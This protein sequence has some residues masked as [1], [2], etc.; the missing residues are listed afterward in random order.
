MK[1]KRFYPLAAAVLAIQTAALLPSCKSDAP[2]NPMEFVEVT[3]HTSITVPASGASYDLE[4][5]SNTNW[6]V[7]FGEAGEW[8]TAEPVKGTG[9]SSVK[10]TVAPYTDGS[11]AR[12][13]TIR[14]SS[15]R[16]SSTGVD[17]PLTQNPPAQ[18]G[19]A[20]TVGEIRAL[21]SSI[22]VSEPTYT[23]TQNVKL[24]VNVYSDPSQ[25]NFRENALAIQDGT[26]AN[27]GIVLQ[28]AAALQYPAG[29][30]LEIDVRNA[31]LT[32]DAD[33]ILVLQAES[34]SKITSTESTA[35]NLTPVTTDLAG[36][37]SG[38]YESMYVEIQ[39][40]E[41]IL[42]ETEDAMA[43][44]VTMENFARD[45]FFMFTYDYALFASEKVPAGSGNLRGIVS[46]SGG[47]PA[48]IPQSAADFSL[49]G[50]RFGKK[51]ITLPHILSL[52][53]AGTSNTAG[54]KYSTRSTLD[55]EPLLSDNSNDALNRDTD[56]MYVYP[57]DN[58]GV[59]LRF[60]DLTYGDMLT[61][62]AKAGD[63]RIVFWHENSGHHNLPCKSFVEI[64]GKEPH[65]LFEYPLAESL[66]AGEQV[67]FSFGISSTGTA[68]RNWKVKYSI[69]DKVN[70]I[71]D[72]A[73][74][75]VSYA[76]P[77][78]MAVGSSKNFFYA[79]T[80]ITPAT[81]LPIGS[82]LWIKVGLFDDTS[83]NG[84]IVASGG[85]SRVHS[86]VVIDKK[87]SGVTATPAGALYFEPFDRIFGGF[88]YLWG[89]KLAG[90]VA[91]AGKDISEWDAAQ[92]AGLSGTNVRER[93]GYVQ[94]GYSDVEL[95][96]AN[97]A[98]F[99]NNAGSLTTPAL[100]G[101]AA[102]QNVKLSFRAMS[103]K[104]GCSTAWTAAKDYDGDITRI[105]VSLSGSGTISGSS[106]DGKSIVVEGLSRTAFG[107]FELNIDGAGPD[108]KITFTS[109]SGLG[110]YVFT[111]WF[112]DDI[113]V[114]AR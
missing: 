104:T 99:K 55:G 30:E 62:D 13:A 48:V 82:T 85:E 63:R 56:N 113:C 60:I 61:S 111:R 95:I 78:N 28:G 57:N 42:D 26:A 110:D 72:D 34:D 2:E 24:T 32:K 75:G 108:T 31:T 71:N 64:E 87:P 43:G 44:A 106:G 10:I 52:M 27:S 67:R 40:V 5:S 8:I 98:D 12:T 36:L 105:L 29:A 53:A 76:V 91:Y 7:T 77:T 59:E 51:G 38:D 103:Y 50:S 102:G 66:A 114:T 39:Q 41:V 3:N 79:S 83:N 6:A 94:L 93:V 80:Y 11:A 37:V 96:A 54:M 18:E 68:P 89:D 23:I 112:L 21:A 22:T 20:I 1:V 14:V 107:T 109:E 88:D 65:F 86:A 84:G 16:D 46:A 70:W 97:S 35:I 49:T 90:M 69:D 4:V 101:V 17:I 58:T 9:T 47:L 45:N 74:N 73:G 81:D 100:T 33:G 25:G 92:K 19:T 15:Q